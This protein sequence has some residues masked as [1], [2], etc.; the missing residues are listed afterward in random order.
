[1]QEINYLKNIIL[2]KIHNNNNEL[3]I[4]NKDIISNLQYT[5]D[6]PRDPLLFTQ[7]LSSIEVHSHSTTSN[8]ENNNKISQILYEAIDNSRK[9]EII[10]NNQLNLLNSNNDKEIYLL[11]QFLVNCLSG[12]QRKIAKYYFNEII[13]NN[14]NN[15]SNNNSNSNNINSQSDNNYRYNEY[16]GYI[17]VICLTIYLIGSSLY[18]FLFG[19]RIGSKA[20][21]I[22]LLGLFISILQSFFLVQPL[23]IWI[24]FILFSIIA[25]KIR[26]WHALL[27]EIC[28]TI[29]SRNKGMIINCEHSII[30]HLN[31]ACRAARNYPL[32][33]TSR[34]I[35]SLNDYDL[36]VNSIENINNN[37]QI[38]SIYHKLFKKSYLLILLLMFGLTI[39]PEFIQESVII[40]I[41]NVF[42]SIFLIGMAFLNQNSII[43][44]IMICFGLLILF[45]LREI[46]STVSFKNLSRIVTPIDN[47]TYM[48]YNDN[49]SHNNNNTRNNNNDRSNIYAN[50]VTEKE[51]LQI[52][53][54]ENNILEDFPFIN[55]NRERIKMESN[56]FHENDVIIIDNKSNISES[57]IKTDNNRSNNIKIKKSQILPQMNTIIPD[58]DDYDSSDIKLNSKIKSIV[59]QELS[60]KSTKLFI[61][62]DSFENNYNKMNENNDNIIDISEEYSKNVSNLNIFS[63]SI[64]NDIIK[65]KDSTNLNEFTDIF[66]TTI[67]IKEEI[68]INKNLKTSNSSIKKESNKTGK[69][70]IIGPSIGL[71][72]QKVVETKLV[73]QIGGIVKL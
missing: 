42:V 31:P 6:K 19:L 15:N 25:N 61:K 10:I 35:M 52:I 47:I 73:L 4:K 51:K 12:I 3:L 18:I 63:N 9:D 67:T 17:C 22:W 30:Q 32:L 62:T 68:I 70:K 26:I 13:I 55:E 64:E 29:I 36:P 21:D 71:L 14:T 7:Y 39:L 24:K 50:N 40:G 38:Q 57:I 33:I 56:F 45:I 8:I 28:A 23:Q 72:N 69:H 66:D 37:N 43:A 44:V 11:Q 48:I 59:T 65:S 49:D 16:M 41:A 1:M 27:R 2:K 53:K 46:Y 58:D 34:L 5:I 54:K 60:P 20:T